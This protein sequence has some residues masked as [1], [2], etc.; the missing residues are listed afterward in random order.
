MN[1]STYNWQQKGWPRFSFDREALRG[2]LD[3][4]AD[5]VKSVR[6]AFDAPE[7]LQA[8]VELLTTEAVRTSAIEGVNVDES[9]VMSSI[10]RV[11][12]VPYAP[13]GFRQGCPCRRG[14]E[15]D[16]CRARGLAEADFASAHPLVAPGIDVRQCARHCRGMLSHPCRTDARGASYGIRRG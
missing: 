7:D 8:V 9:V 16:A 4:F 12:G 13:L 15:D 10:C 2:A 5:A 3:D 1:A 14:G 6:G 11:L